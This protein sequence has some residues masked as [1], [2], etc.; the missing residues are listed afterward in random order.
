MTLAVG[1]SCSAMFIP[2]NHDSR[3]LSHILES[4]TISPDV[5]KPA[6]IALICLDLL[7]FDLRITSLKATV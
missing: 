5:C 2:H 6:T 1:P 4:I 3:A 7:A